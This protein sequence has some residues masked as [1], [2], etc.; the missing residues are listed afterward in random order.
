MGVEV[1]VIPEHAALD[2]LG[3]F[4]LHSKDNVVDVPRLLCER[5]SQGEGSRL[6]SVR[7]HVEQQEH[8]WHLGLTISEA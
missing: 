2:E 1:K 8:V 7:K 4:F 6:M 5:A 3:A